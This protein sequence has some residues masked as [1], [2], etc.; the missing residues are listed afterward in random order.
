MSKAC[1]C[2]QITCTCALPDPV[3]L[4]RPSDPNVVP[5]KEIK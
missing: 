5:T 4:E 2:G 1:P 3:Q